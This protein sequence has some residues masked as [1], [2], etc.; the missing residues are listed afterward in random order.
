MLIRTIAKSVLLACMLG[1]GISPLLAQNTTIQIKD[2]ESWYGGAVN[3]AH[4]APFKTGYS[5][6]LFADTRGNQAVPLLVSTKGR[7][8]WSEEPFKFTFNGKQ[9]VITDA[10]AALTVDSAGKTLKDAVA[11]AGKRFFPSKQKLPDTLL[12]SSPQYNTWIELVYNQNQKDII[13]YAKDILANG[14]PAGVLMIDDN[15]GDYYGRFDF[16][17]DRF[18][19]AAGMVD[20]LHQLGFKVMLWISPFV[21]PDTEVFRELQAKKLLLFDGNAGKPWA[22]AEKPALISWWNGYSAVMD[23]TNPEATKW[24]QSRLD[25]M[26]NTY[27]LDGFKFDAGDADFYPA[28]GVSFA[29]ATPND[30]SRLWGE[31]GLKYPLNEYR[32]M[33][34][35]AGEPLVQRLR[36]KQHTWVDLQKLVPHLTAAGL[37]GYQ[38]TCPDMIGGGEYGSFIGRDKLDEELVVRS[39][40]CSALM[41][42]MQFSVAPWRVLSKEHLAMVKT[43]VDIRKKYTSY[44]LQLAKAAALTGEPIARSMEYAFPNQGLSAV[45]GQFM[46]GDKY[47]VAP[48]AEKG[49]KKT[50]MLPKGKWKSDEGEIIKGPRAIAL[51]VPLNRLPVFE[52]VK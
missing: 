51:V 44:I 48:V 47:L 20:T 28:N 7:F 27:H 52:L 11:N 4:L 49:G 14:F 8:V 31:I 41:P 37:M 46:L 3:D 30:H 43:T 6:N 22:E 39:A 34:K 16:R 29:K 35:M 32:A 1:A 25:H 23:F 10:L 38:F 19:D 24:F 12:F 2:G 36:D 21:S 9:L 40:Q 42:M 15:W 18:T 5:L 33:W 13:K 17:K 45:S 26:V 50:I